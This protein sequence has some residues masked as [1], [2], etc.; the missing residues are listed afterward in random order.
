VRDTGTLNLGGSV[1]TAGSLVFIGATNDSRLRAF[2]SRNGKLLW[3]TKLEA[4]AHSSPITY[5]GR[6]GRQYL[7]VMAAGGGA[8]LG[9]GLSDTL[10]AFALPD[11]ARKPLPVSKT[12]VGTA[13]AQSGRAIVGPSVPVTPPPGGAKALMEKT[14]GTACH[15]LDVVTSQRMKSEEWNAIVQNMIARGAQASDLEAKAI[16]EYL[17][18]TFGSKKQ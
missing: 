2:D 18:K 12:R 15:S 6:D 1:A 3:E 16:V 13:G 5:M 8:F 7:A 9:G 14:C 17:A 10:V 11:V 4:S